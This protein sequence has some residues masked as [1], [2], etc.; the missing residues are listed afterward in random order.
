M[1]NVPEEVIQAVV[2]EVAALT[3]APERTKLSVVQ[4]AKQDTIGNAPRWAVDLVESFEANPLT[5]DDD[6]EVCAK[7]YIAFAW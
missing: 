1:K 6:K 2:I 3:D 4:V 7:R 5:G